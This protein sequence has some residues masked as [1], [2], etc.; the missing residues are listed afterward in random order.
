LTAWSLV[1]HRQGILVDSS[2]HDAL[3]QVG[4]VVTGSPRRTR[5]A[6]T[7]KALT[8]EAGQRLFLANG[9]ESAI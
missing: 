7:L 6:E 1:H 5:A 9:F 8:G 4:G 2:L 3:R